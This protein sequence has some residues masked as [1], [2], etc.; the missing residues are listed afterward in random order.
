MAERIRFP[1]NIGTTHG[2]NPAIDG[3]FE[4]IDVDSFRHHQLINE[5]RLVAFTATP[6]PRAPW[7]WSTLAWQVTM[8]TTVLPGVHVE[9]VLYGEGEQLVQPQGTRPAK[10]YNDTR[11]ALVVRTPLAARQLGT[12]DLAVDFG[13][14]FEL[15]QRIDEVKEMI[16]AEVK[17]AFPSSG[18]VT[19]RGDDIP[20]DI[21]IN[22]FVVDVPLKADVPNWFDADIDMSLGFELY[23][24]DGRVAA[25]YSFATV[26]VSFGVASTV[27][28]AGCSRA[29]GKALEVSAEGFFDGFIGPAIARQMRDK[30]QAG[31]NAAME[32][33]NRNRTPKYKVYDFA[34]TETNLLVRV[35]P[36]S[37]PATP[38]TPVDNGGVL[39]GGVGPIL[40]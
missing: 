30:V 26:D 14:C 13:A 27:L 19:L 8:P 11:Y 15:P 36:E 21:G 1:R 33:F 2:G 35:C 6:N 5:A 31:M 20:V 25:K 17:R 32:V 16:R 22:A 24:V 39:G 38:P 12:V 7:D 28:S 23:P 37:R 18:Q 10:P 4:P 29:V 40:A 3:E 34:L 9:L